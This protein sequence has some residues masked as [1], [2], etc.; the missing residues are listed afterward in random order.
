[1]P[2]PCVDYVFGDLTLHWEAGSDDRLVLVEDGILGINAAPVRRQ[3][4]PKSRTSGPLVFQAYGH[5]RVIPV[6]A[7]MSIG[8]T[9]HENGLTDAYLAAY[10]ALEA[11]VVSKLAAKLNTPTS[12]AWTPTGGGAQ[13]VTC[14][15]GIDGEAVEFTGPAINRLCS[16]TLI[17]AD[18][19][20]T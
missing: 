17:E 4:D 10:N 3:R 14:V 13:S 5:G 1:M 19:I 9:G 18:A 6:R 2:A 20:I 15:Y 16:F 11:S 7:T 12:L 8:S